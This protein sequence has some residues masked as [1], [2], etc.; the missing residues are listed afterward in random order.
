MLDPD[1]DTG[2]LI[3]R[4]TEKNILCGGACAMSVFVCVCLVCEMR[5]HGIEKK[6]YISPNKENSRCTYYLFILYVVCVCGRHLTEGSPLMYGEGE[7]GFLWSWNFM[8][9]KVYD[10]V[11]TQ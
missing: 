11:A 2:A 4:N 8:I 5:S 9:S 6:R 3:S 1:N 10:V 7:T